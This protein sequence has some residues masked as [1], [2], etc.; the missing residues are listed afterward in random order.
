M[1]AALAA[2]AV[3]AEEAHRECTGQEPLGVLYMDY[4]GRDWW[5]HKE[6]E[7]EYSAPAGMGSAPVDTDQ[8]YTA[9]RAAGWG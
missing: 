8:D 1:L 3:V 6:A 9:G 4:T 5:G 2:V 7:E